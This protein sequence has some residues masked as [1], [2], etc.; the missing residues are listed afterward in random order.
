MQMGYSNKL[1]PIFKISS[2]EGLKEPP[3]EVGVKKDQINSR[4][5]VLGGC[6]GLL[7]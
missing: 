4:A 1:N 7:D 3:P 6:S 2:G 5:S